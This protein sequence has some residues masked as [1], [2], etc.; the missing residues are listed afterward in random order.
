MGQERPVPSY[1]L[2]GIKVSSLEEKCFYP[3]SEVL[4]QN[5]MPVSPDVIATATDFERWPYYDLLYG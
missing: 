5:E 1:S 2:F 4:T 3:L